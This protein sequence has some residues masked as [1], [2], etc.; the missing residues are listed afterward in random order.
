MKKSNA[1]K[2][3]VVVGVSLFATSAVAA[4]QLV[5][6]ANCLA[7]IQAPNPLTTISTG[8]ANDMLNVAKTLSPTSQ[9]ALIPAL[10]FPN[11]ATPNWNWA[12]G[13]PL[14][15][16][17]LLN[18]STSGFNPTFQAPYWNSATNA[19]IDTS[20][21]PWNVGVPSDAFSQALLNW[22]PTESSLFN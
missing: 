22:G 5:D 19:L 16:S 2:I 11:Q 13:A 6:C 17:N 1:W 12:A 14:P 20:S 15:G 9:T 8:N 3:L 21:A 10:Y 18:F 7:N 4:T